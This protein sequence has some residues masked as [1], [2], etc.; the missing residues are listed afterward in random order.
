MTEHSYS[1][2]LLPFSTYAQSILHKE[3]LAQ[4]E[5]KSKTIEKRKKDF[6]KWL[7]SDKR[8]KSRQTLLSNE[9]PPE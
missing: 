7:N 5:E 3:A 9:V 8:K 6:F 4:V 1:L 2:H